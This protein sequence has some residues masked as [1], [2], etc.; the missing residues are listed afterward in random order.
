VPLA[1][2]LPLVASS[3]TALNHNGVYRRV[4]EWKWPV[5]GLCTRTN[6]LSAR[7]L[8]AGLGLAQLA[9]RSVLEGRGEVVWAAS[10][11]SLLSCLW[12]RG[13]MNKQLSFWALY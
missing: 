13:A 4:P 6:Q 2:W 11:P 3:S 12:P 8:L 7:A 5:A 1:G 9:V 10:T